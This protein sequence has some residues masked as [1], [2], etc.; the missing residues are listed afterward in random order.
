M[1]VTE[2]FVSLARTT[3]EVMGVPDLRLIHIPHPIAGMAP[4]RIETYATSAIN[5]ILRLFGGAP[6]ERK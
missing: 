3:A 6:A 4:D 5:S 2:Q 1:L